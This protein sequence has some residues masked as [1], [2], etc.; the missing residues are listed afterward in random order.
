MMELTEGTP[1]FEVRVADAID[2]PAVP[3]G[4]LTAASRLVAS[5]YGDERLF[6]QHS[7][8]PKKP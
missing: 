1:L 4:R 2:A 5:R 8:G 3:L 6:F 7:I